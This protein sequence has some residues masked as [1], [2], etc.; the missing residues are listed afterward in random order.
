[1]KYLSL[2]P[3]ASAFETIFD[4][5]ARVSAPTLRKLTQEFAFSPALDV[6]ETDQE[7][8]VNFDIPGMTKDDL[9]IEIHES[10][11]TVS[12]ERKRL[13]TK[14]VKDG[15]EA[16]EDKT[17]YSHFERSFGRFERTLSL[18]KNVDPAKI[19]ARA[20]NG[21]LTVQI[22]KTVEAQPRQIAIQ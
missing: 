14:E 13:T 18:P 4:D 7:Y 19:A 16:K 17:F 22:P 11:L 10:K 9:K 8:V 5:V 21:V 6:V 2:W 20:E 15:A 12:G 1:M 3:E